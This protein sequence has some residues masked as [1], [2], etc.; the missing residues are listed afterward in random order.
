MMSIR[1]TAIAGR[2]NHRSRF[3]AR[4]DHARVQRRGIETIEREVDGLHLV[5]PQIGD[6]ATE[7]G[8]DAGKARHD[9]RISARPL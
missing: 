3:L 5:V 6:D 4:R 2:R 9:R 1:S 8:G 7:R